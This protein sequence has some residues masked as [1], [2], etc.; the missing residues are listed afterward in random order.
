M[1]HAPAC[2]LESI[3][4]TGAMPTGVN[5]PPH[6]KRK[7]AAKKKYREHGGKWILKLEPGIPVRP[8]D[9][10][11][12][13]YKN[14]T[15]EHRQ[16]ERDT[17]E[18]AINFEEQCYTELRR[19]INEGVV[20]EEKTRFLRI[21]RKL[22]I[23]EDQRAMHDSIVGEAER[24]EEAAEGDRAAG[25]EAAIPV[26][27]M[28]PRGGEEEIP[29]KADKGAVGKRHLRWRVQRTLNGRGHEND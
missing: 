17:L 22:E 9:L 16:I 8:I 25:V 3:V 18:D 26:H 11:D 10:L 23:P 1:L 28:K 4:K 14:S 20:G 19:I 13:A 12:P 5:V 7:A 15:V 27:A 24:G 2:W 6:V 21:Q 29:E